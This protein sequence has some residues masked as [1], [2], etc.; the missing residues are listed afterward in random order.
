MY[1]LYFLEHPY[2][3]MILWHYYR[4]LITPM[5][6]PGDF[7]KNTSQTLHISPLNWLTSPTARLYFVAI[8]WKHV[9]GKKIRAAINSS[10]YGAS[11]GV[12]HPAPILG[13]S[14]S[15]IASDISPTSAII[16]FYWAEKWSRRDLWYVT[17]F[18]VRCLRYYR[19]H[20]RSEP[21][22]ERCQIFI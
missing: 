9:Y 10:S 14:F 22:C 11:G 4:T 18:W 8:H 3:V 1:S 16:T 19:W 21:S 20:L 12:Q 17:Y 5:R 15:L 7:S 2:S 13:V 6:P